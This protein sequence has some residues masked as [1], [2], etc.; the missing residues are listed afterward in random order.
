VAIFVKGFNMLV[1]VRKPG[2]EVLVGDNCRIVVMGIDGQRVRLG[3]EAPRELSI[4]R[5]EER[6]RKRKEEGND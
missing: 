5:L 6:D 4:D 2:Q 1:I 3:F